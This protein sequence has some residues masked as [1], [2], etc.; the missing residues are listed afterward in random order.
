MISNKDM[1]AMPTQAT[2]NRDQDKFL[3]TQTDN[4]DFL[5]FGLTKREH[6]AGLAMQAILSNPAIINDLNVGVIDWVVKRANSVATEQLA[7][8]DKVQ[9]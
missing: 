5:L 9:K 7:E 4:N 2:L 8:L 6:F 3:E 1:P